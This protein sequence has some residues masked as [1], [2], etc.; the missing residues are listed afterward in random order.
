MLNPEDVV[1]MDSWIDYAHQKLGVAYP[2]AKTKPA[3]LKMSTQFFEAHPD[4]TWHALVDLVRWAKHTR[5]TRHY[6]IQELLGSWQYAH[7]EGYMTI[8]S[9]L[10]TNDDETLNEM[11]KSVHDPVYADRMKIAR[12]ATERNEVYAEYLEAT[13][14][15]QPVIND[16]TSPEFDDL[17]LSSGMVMRY[18]LTVAEQPKM[19]TLLRQDGDNLVIYTGDREVS[20]PPRLLSIKIDG[21]W[22]YL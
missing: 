8:L 3:M 12:T 16:D 21:A 15:G 13:D 11:L 18:R 20:L 5:K 22:D 7:Q 17:R 19:G 4:A 14:G 6:D 1:D 10:G 2:T 9:R